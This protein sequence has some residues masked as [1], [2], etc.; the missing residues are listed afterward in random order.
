TPTPKPTATPT[1]KPTATPTPKPTATPTPKPTATP[2]P[3]PTPVPTPTPKPTPVPTPTP[4]PTPVPTPTPKPTPVPTPTPKPTPVPTATPTPTPTP[5]ATPTPTPTPTV[6]PIPTVTPTPSKPVLY[7]VGQ[8]VWNDNNKNGI[9]DP[10]EAP[11]PNATV[12]LLNSNGDVIATTTTDSNG[13]FLFSNLPA[14]DYS[15]KVVKPDGYSFSPEHAGNDRLLDSDADNIGSISKF[16]LSQTNSNP[17][18]DV[19]IYKLEN[20]A[21]PAVL[22]KTGNF[23]DFEL[24]VGIGSTMLILGTIVLKKKKAK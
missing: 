11:V 9:I 12:K 13:K 8:Y 23:V 16:T 6:T 7:S 10:G 21:A 19:G 5:T 24:L 15:I 18:F 1:P 14:G 22:P 17:V 3:K 4:K 2:T 20:T